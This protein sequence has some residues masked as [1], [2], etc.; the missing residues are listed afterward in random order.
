MTEFIENLDEYRAYL[1][2]LVMADGCIV[3][4]NGCFRM[5]LALNIKDADIIHKLHNHFKVGSICISKDSSGYKEQERIRWTVYDHN[6]VHGLMELSIVPRKTGI[7]RLPSIPKELMRHFMRGFFDGDGYV[8]CKYNERLTR[9]IHRIGFA[10]NYEMGTDIN[11][12]FKDE[13]SIT[14]KKLR[15]N[16]KSKVSYLLE[17]TGAN[18][19]RLIYDYFYTDST[20]FLDRKLFIYKEL[21][22]GLANKKDKYHGRIY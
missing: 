17:L 3:Y 19:L 6:I 8:M 13:L 14:P 10:L 2:G 7:E 16:G 1:A 21:V 18:D 5:T 22:D 4:Q 11:N 20:I 15:Q 12:L 9:N